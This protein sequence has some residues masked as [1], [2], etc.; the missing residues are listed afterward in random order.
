MSERQLYTKKHT[1]KTPSKYRENSE[2]T[3]TKTNKGLT[4]DRQNTEIHPKVTDA[5]RGERACFLGVDLIVKRVD[6]VEADYKSSED[7]AEHSQPLEKVADGLNGAE[8]TSESTFN[9]N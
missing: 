4:K 8:Y 9:K 3:L 2:K 1:D 6:V 7:I 5:E